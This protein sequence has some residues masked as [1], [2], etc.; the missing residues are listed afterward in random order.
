VGW[1]VK[2]IRILL[3]SLDT[4]LIQGILFHLREDQGHP[5]ELGI[6]VVFVRVSDRK[7]W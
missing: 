1:T 2:D 3:A 4:G 7:W 6:G 5:T